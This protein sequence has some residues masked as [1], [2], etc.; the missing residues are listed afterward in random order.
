MGVFNATV[1]SDRPGSLIR[2]DG[3]APESDLEILGAVIAFGVR[4]GL[5]SLGA[6]ALAPCVATP[7]F[8]VFLPAGFGWTI[9]VV[10]NLLERRHASH[11]VSASGRCDGTRTNGG[12]SLG[13]RHQRLS[14]CFE[15][16]AKPAPNSPVQ[17]PRL[18]RH[19][20]SGPKWIRD[21]VTLEACA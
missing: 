11:I 6:P 12:R 8:D 1:S 20:C 13:Q 4:C 3:F 5:H 9:S 7:F 15:V 14:V 10:V 19:L 18:R 17:T 21:K 16:A 2:V